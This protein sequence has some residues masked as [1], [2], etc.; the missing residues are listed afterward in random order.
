MHFGSTKEN[1][2]KRNTIKCRPILSYTPDQNEIP[3]ATNV[4]EE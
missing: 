1:E 2:W 4:L 3:T